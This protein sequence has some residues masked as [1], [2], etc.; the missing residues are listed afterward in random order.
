MRQQ[1]VFGFE[2]GLGEI[3][4]TFFGEAPF[5]PAAF[6]GDLASIAKMYILAHAGDTPEPLCRLR[7]EKNGFGSVAEPDLRKAVLAIEQHHMTLTEKEG[8]MNQAQEKHHMHIVLTQ[9][10]YETLSAKAQA[11]GLSR[12][13]FLA[14]LI[15]GTPVKARPPQELRALRIELNRIGILINQIARKANA[16]LA[17]REEIQD[18]FRLLAE[19]HQLL[20]KAAAPWQ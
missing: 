11:C 19:A 13:A 12:R 17:N 7:A 15:E 3:A 8:T 16:G 18:A 1:G 10:Q 4:G 5:T 9:S 14:R 2:A 6:G 20:E